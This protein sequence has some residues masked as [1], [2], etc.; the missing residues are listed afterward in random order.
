MDR[1]D[2]NKLLDILPS[3]ITY[4]N[5]HQNID[6][7]CCRVH[8]VSE[9]VIAHTQYETIVHE[10][11]HVW[12]HKD[13]ISKN[14]D[15]KELYKKYTDEYFKKHYGASAKKEDSLFTRGSIY[16]NEKE[17]LAYSYSFY[18]LKY[19]DPTEGYKDYDYPE[20]IKKVMDKYTC[21]AKNIDNSMC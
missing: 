1:G 17:F 5:S 18:Y 6:I 19:V 7:L 4:G 13:N 20:D 16:T 21:L 11:V 3:G 2:I 10:L 14:N 12:D 15:I 8:P 9:G